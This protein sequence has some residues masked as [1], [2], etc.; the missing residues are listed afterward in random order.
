[1]LTIEK[2]YFIIVCRHFHLLFLS[3]IADKRTTATILLSIDTGESTVYVQFT[4]VAELRWGLRL[5]KVVLLCLSI[6]NLLPTVATYLWP[7]EHC[8]VK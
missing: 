1:M 2:F 6:T 7:T 5:I 4:T 3:R 8:Q